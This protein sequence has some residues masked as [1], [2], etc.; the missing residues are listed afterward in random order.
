MLEN[1]HY[2][3]GKQRDD[4]DQI[5][6]Q[7][8]LMG[9]DKISPFGTNDRKV[10]KRKLEKSSVAKLTAM[11][12]KTATRM[13]ADKEDQ[14]NALIK[15]FDEWRSS[16]WNNSGSKTEEITKALAYDTLNDFESE[17]KTKTLS[18]L[19]EVAMKLGFTPSFDRVRLLSALKQ[20]Y[21]KRG[22]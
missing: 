17:M 13:Y 22:R 9:I 12:E 14:I 6:A 19:Q 5:E 7:E 16:N 1:L 2:T 8:K 11:A 4:I 3:D 18:E 10:L 21:L 15:S 20:E